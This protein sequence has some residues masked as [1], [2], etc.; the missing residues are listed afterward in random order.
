MFS[1]RASTFE[2]FVPQPQNTVSN[3]HCETFEI[4]L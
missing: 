1:K 4:K 3:E 2:N